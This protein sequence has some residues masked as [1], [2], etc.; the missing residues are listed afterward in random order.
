[1]SVGWD[2]AAAGEGH[3]EARTHPP[4]PCWVVKQTGQSRVGV[5]GPKPTHPDVPWRE[6]LAGDA[7]TASR[8]GAPKAPYL[9]ALF[10]VKS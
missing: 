5:L 7:P 6:T 1:M 10:L 3:A 4:P 2:G 8:P 9:P